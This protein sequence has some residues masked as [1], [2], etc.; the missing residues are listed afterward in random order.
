[1]LLSCEEDFELISRSD[2]VC[3]SIYKGRNIA[4]NYVVYGSVLPVVE[5]ELL[6]EHIDLEQHGIIEIRFEKEEKLE[7]FIETFK[8][9]K[10]LIEI[11]SFRKINVEKVSAYS[12][13]IVYSL[14]EK[15]IERSIEVYGQDIQENEHSEHSRNHIWKWI[16]L[17]ELIAQ[18]S[19]EYYFDKHEMLSP[20]IELFLEPLYAG[21]NSETRIFLNIVQ[22]LET[23][24]SRFVTNDF[25]EF[26]RRIEKITNNFSSTKSE[27]LR[28]FFMA[29][30]KS[31]ITLESRI[32]DLLFA[33]GEICFDTGEIKHCEFP[34]IITHT[35]NYYIHYDERI[36]ENYRVLTKKELQFY[37][38]SLLQMLEYYILVEL[39][40]SDSSVLKRK[41]S[42]RWGKVSQDMEILRISR[43]QNN[44]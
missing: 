25:D 7:K 39:G 12:N 9:L 8:K 35:R 22:A 21:N 38:R 30:S 19:F 28:K 42:E 26:K 20:V 15:I 23:Y 1:M 4:I 13:D 41:L 5:Q 6:K 43:V 44:L 29:K 36:K 16:S 24:H 37:N 31:F 34:A 11:A 18:N 32:S 2:N 3:K 40:F 17:S 14:G 10:R 27:E 33:N